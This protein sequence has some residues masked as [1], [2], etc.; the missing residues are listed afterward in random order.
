MVD[1]LRDR[2]ND[3][4]ILRLAETQQKNWGELIIASWTYGAEKCGW[5]FVGD[6]KEG[7][8]PEFAV[9]NIGRKLPGLK[10]AI[11]RPIHWGK[12]TVIL[13]EEANRWAKWASP[14]NIGLKTIKDTKFSS[15]FYLFLNF[16]LNLNS[17][18]MK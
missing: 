4:V 8:K 2:K 14:I 5:S 15:F 9:D 17:K 18:K 12:I 1:T 3:W 6:T 10:A 7:D 13:S 16:R 11:N